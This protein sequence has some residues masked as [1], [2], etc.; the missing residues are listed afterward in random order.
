[1]KIKIALF[2]V[3]FGMSSIII[4]VIFTLYHEYLEKENKI[5]K[6]IQKGLNGIHISE[7]EEQF[8]IFKEIRKN[9]IF[10]IIKFK[11]RFYVNKKAK[12][13]SIYMSQINFKRILGSMVE[14]ENLNLP[15][16]MIYRDRLVNSF[17]KISFVRKYLFDKNNF[18][19]LFS[20][21]ENETHNRKRIRKFLLNAFKK[22]NK[23]IYYINK[24]IEFKTNFKRI[25][26]LT[27][28]IPFDHN[29]IS[30]FGQKDILNISCII[31]YPNKITIYLPEINSDIDFITFQKIKVE[32]ERQDFDNFHS[33]IFFYVMST[34]SF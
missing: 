11:D 10:L 19:R 23:N 18:T 33:S 12:N 27:Q 28:E 21:S 14:S 32:V 1:M 7:F 17:T 13:S 6:C 20:Y 24:Y 16:K 9:E 34:T 31:F 2:H 3:F 29:F 25:L 4:L 8:E 5:R 15:T 26:D 22:F 30:I